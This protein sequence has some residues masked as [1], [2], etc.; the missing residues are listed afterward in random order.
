MVTEASFSNWRPGKNPV[1]RVGVSYGEWP[2]HIDFIEGYTMFRSH[3]YKQLENQIK[4]TL[5]SQQ[6]NV[7]DK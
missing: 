7:T 3:L 1:L 2:V 5:K 4:T 6:F